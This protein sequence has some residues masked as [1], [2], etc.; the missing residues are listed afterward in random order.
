MKDRD[1]EAWRTVLKLHSSGS[2]DD[3]AAATFA[4]EEYYQMKMQVH[5]DQA[6]AAEETVST[7]FTKPSYRKRMFCAFMTM[8]GTE[9]TGILVIY[10]TSDIALCLHL[11]DVLILAQTT[12]CSFTKV[13]GFL[14]QSR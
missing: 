14:P 3:S 13:L 1:D 10:S 4:K 9:S 2:D 11:I 12:V 6:I 8:F 5:R 7:L